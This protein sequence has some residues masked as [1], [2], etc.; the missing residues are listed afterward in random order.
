MD[1]DADF[2]GEGLPE[3][4]LTEDFRKVQEAMEPENKRILQE[5]MLAV[6]KAAKRRFSTL[7]G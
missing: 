1:I 4:C 7:L 5:Q 2:V 3:D 6:A